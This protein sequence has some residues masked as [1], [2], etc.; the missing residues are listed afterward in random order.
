MTIL[1]EDSVDVPTL[2]ENPAEALHPV[3]KHLKGWE[4]VL[5]T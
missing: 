1:V 4:E 5:V 2:L 3:L